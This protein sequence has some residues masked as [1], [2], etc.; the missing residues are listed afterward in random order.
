[1]ARPRRAVVL[2]AVAGAVA[3]AV[4]VALFAS[5]ARERARD[6]DV[7]ELTVVWQADGAGV[8]PRVEA[9]TTCHAMHPKA[10]ALVAAHPTATFGC[11]SCHGG[12]G[13]GRDR[14]H[15]H[16]RVV[17]RAR[18]DGAGTEWA[19]EGFTPGG[20][21]A[22]LRVGAPMPDLPAATDAAPAADAARD[23]FVL[24]LPEIEGGCLK[25]HAGDEALAGAPE[26]A[27]GR[28]LFRDLGCHACHASPLAAAPKPGLPLSDVSRRLTP[29]H[30]LDVLR[31]PEGATPGARMPSAWPAGARDAGRREETL[32]V[33]AFLIDKS[34]ARAR[35]SEGREVAR[36]AEVPGASAEDG[37]RIYE[38]YGCAAC[39]EGAA[40]PDARPLA[41]SL[42]AA[43]EAWTADW[44]AAWSRDPKALYAAARMPSL[45]LS[46]REA[47]SVAQHLA[48]RRGPARVP[49]EDVA[50]LT[51]PARRA[52][53]V[54]CGAAPGGSPLPR[55]ECGARLTARYA[56]VACHELDGVAAPPPGPSL[57]GF[58]ARARL[59]PRATLATLSSAHLADPAARMPSY[60]LSPGELRALMV[61]L[62]GF[63]DA[64]PAVFADASQRPA[65]QARDAGRARMRALQCSACHAEGAARGAPSLDGEGARVRP[66]WLFAM[67][68]RPERHG[69][70]PALH[71][72]WL[73][74]ELAPH[75]ALAPRMP[76]YAL[77]P[78]DATAI[79]RGL[80]AEA[81]ARFPFTP[82]RPAGLSPDERARA[83]AAL[84]AQCLGCHFV[85][86]LPRERARAFGLASLAPSLSLASERL[87]EE[88]LRAF[89][90]GHVS[91]ALPPKLVDLVLWLRPGTVLPRAGEESRV[92]VLGLGD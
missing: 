77:S 74:G 76:S 87:R 35:R 66:E 8:R 53:V 72:E 71:P 24:A 79:V 16:A 4:A 27:R 19:A 5:R 78:D 90:P 20:G 7:R 69:V 34:E 51:D 65:Q 42:T 12:D 80:A 86:E 64:A 57:Q 43:G 83:A 82:P 21:E 2:A 17:L 33:A 60:A 52:E 62:A 67:L 54:P 29:A 44:M 1:M 22:L 55:T 63:G 41:P 25:C 47:A 61:L 89:V 46:F 48:S 15:P 40:R 70:R 84:R 11:T 49:A 91:G 58:A 45:R 73:Y 32:A 59:S 38:A 92:P 3:L 56:C 85:G 81:G 9:C 28:A 39:H 30:L 31:D 75:A 36:A 23:A 50:I 10:A 68:E 26:L 6:A 13:A 37:R 14:A 18:R 88:W